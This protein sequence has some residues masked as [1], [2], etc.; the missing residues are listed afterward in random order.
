MCSMYLNLNS[1][2]ELHS[3]VDLQC[4]YLQR[5]LRNLK[6]SV[7]LANVPEKILWSIWYVGR[8]ILPLMTLGSL[9]KIWIMLLTLS[10]YLSNLDNVTDAHLLSE[11]PYC[12][13]LVVLGFYSILEVFPTFIIF[14]RFFCDFWLCFLACGVTCFFE[15][16]SSC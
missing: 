16:G 1:I 6:L 15:E 9:Q 10:R 7:L 13:F 4:L 3:H 8:D 5:F 14:F 11:R 12:Y 2:R